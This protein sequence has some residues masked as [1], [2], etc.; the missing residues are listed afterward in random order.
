LGFNVK[1]F[2]LQ[3]LNAKQSV[4]SPT[5]P[6]QLPNQSTPEV[7]PTRTSVM[8]SAAPVTS[9]VMASVTTGIVPTTEQEHSSDDTPHADG[10]D[11]Q[12]LDWKPQDR[13]IITWAQQYFQ[14][15][16]E[17]AKLPSD[18]QLAEEIAAGPSKEDAQS[19]VLLST[20]QWIQKMVNGSI[21]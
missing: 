14:A 8:Q 11:Q 7:I 4:P 13:I 5:T 1:E 3:A 12:N 10:S 21:L 9:V 20:L 15:I 19:G 17:R 16:P 18:R 2:F 6:M